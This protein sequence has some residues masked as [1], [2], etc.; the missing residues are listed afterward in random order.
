VYL[1]CIALVCLAEIVMKIQRRA[2]PIRDCVAIRYATPLSAASY[3]KLFDSPS[4]LASVYCL[5]KTSNVFATRPGKSSPGLA[6]VTKIKTP[7]ISSIPGKYA[8]FEYRGKEGA[9]KQT[10]Q[11]KI[12]EIVARR[13]SQPIRR[14]TSPGRPAATTL[15]GKSRKRTVK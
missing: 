6:L 14:N 7:P 13:P 10:Q 11:T 8:I 15:T 4:Q 9:M 3:V 12:M 1:T 5:N 2:V